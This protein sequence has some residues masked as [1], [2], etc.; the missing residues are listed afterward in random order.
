[1]TGKMADALLESK[2]EEDEEVAAESAE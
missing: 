2:P 1:L